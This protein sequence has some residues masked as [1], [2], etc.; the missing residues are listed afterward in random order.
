MG[1]FT[2]LTGK[3]LGGIANFYTGGL[4]GKVGNFIKDHSGI[5]GKVA[6]DIGRYVVPG[7]VRNAIS[8]ITDSALELVPEGEVKTTL[9]KINDAAQGRNKTLSNTKTD[10]YK[11]SDSRIAPG[12]GS[13]YGS[14]TAPRELKYKESELANIT[15]KKKTK[16]MKRKK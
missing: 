16:R 6:G 13:I 8:S 10:Q 4:A 2:G 9:S 3:A 1:Y 14:S 5:I 12:E 15:K 7:K 11:S